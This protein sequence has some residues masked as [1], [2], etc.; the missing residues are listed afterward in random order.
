MEDTISFISKDDIE[1]NKTNQDWNENEKSNKKEIKFKLNKEK[2][3]KTIKT[4][5][6]SSFKLRPLMTEKDFLNKI[7]SGN[8]QRMNKLNI[9]N[10]QSNHNELTFLNSNN[11]F[12]NPLQSFHKASNDINKSL[13]RNTYSSIGRGRGRNLNLNSKQTKADTNENI[14]SHKDKFI[15]S[16][17]VDYI[18]QHDHIS[19]ILKI[20]DVYEKYKSYTGAIDQDLTQLIDLY[21]SSKQ[22][23]YGNMT[24]SEMNDL[25]KRYKINTKMINKDKNEKLSFLKN[26]DLSKSM[27]KDKLNSTS[28]YSTASDAL[29]EIEIN[30]IIHNTVNSIWTHQQLDEY[31]KSIT[32][33]SEL[34]NKLKYMPFVRETRIDR[35][36]R[37]TLENKLVGIERKV[38]GEEF[39]QSKSTISREFILSKGI[40]FK[41]EVFNYRMLKPISRIYTSMS[42]VNGKIIIFGGQAG[43]KLNDIWELTIDKDNSKITWNK[44]IYSGETPLKRSVHSNVKHGQ[45]E[46]IYY[47]GSH[48]PLDY[49]KIR[50]DFLIYTHSNRSFTIPE[51]TYNRTEV[52]Y[53]KAHVCFCIK[54]NL[55]IQ[56]G[57]D[58][59]EIFLSDSWV[60][61]L[62]SLKWEML[63]SKGNPLGAIA[64]HSCEIVIKSEKLNHKNFDLYKSGDIHITR[65][66]N[67][68]KIKTEG[69]YFFGGIDEY[70]RNYSNLKI[71]KIGKKP[72][73]WL[74]PRLEGKPPKE[75]NSSTINFYEELG[76]LIVYGGK[77]QSGTENEYFSDL[78]VLDLE[79]F[80][81][82]KTNFSYD[83]NISIGKSRSCHSSIIYNHSLIIFGGMNDE[84]YVGSDV[85]YV[86]LD[87]ISKYEELDNE[88]KLRISLLREEK[89][90]KGSK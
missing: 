79:S 68:Y 18:N 2:T 40:F 43:D 84:G 5:F 50:E 54:N 35:T 52:K 49:D 90:Y 32:S 73:E 63:H 71:L 81:W 62:T 65:N 83:S 26:S 59:E 76:I 66:T 10:I 19:N 36:L 45:G 77:N 17:D 7:S 70:N 29:K 82:I 37:K 6:K 41:L 51:R 38:S 75:R 4:Q 47:G 60:L 53:R 23:G 55:V 34:N 25:L 56:G 20:R 21:T 69:V 64:Y 44:I 30:K 14:I 28:Q 3:I 33:N 46:V 67:S 24:I 80:H 15:K 8:T 27:L 61:N 74:N 31:S 57:I 1:T 11:S 86:D 42:I 48:S 12:Y 39:K 58:E 85:Y 16:N 89:K 78:W 87:L 9:S 13:F 88:K 72:C 22:A